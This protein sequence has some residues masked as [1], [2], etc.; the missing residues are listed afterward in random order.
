MTVIVPVSCTWHKE[1][2][3][4]KDWIQFYGSV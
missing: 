2:A 3:S 4:V 1:V